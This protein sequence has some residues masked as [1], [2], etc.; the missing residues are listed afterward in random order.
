[1]HPFF[2]VNWVHP[3]PEVAR[4]PGVDGSKQGCLPAWLRFRF[5]ALCCHNPD[6][7]TYVLLVALALGNFGFQ[8]LNLLGNFVLTISVSILRFGGLG[9]G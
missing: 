4:E 1:V 9:C 6:F 7:G 5:I 8:E 2:V 3:H